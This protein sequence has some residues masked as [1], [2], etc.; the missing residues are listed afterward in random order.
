MAIVSDFKDMIE[1]FSNLSK[2]EITRVTDAPALITVLI[3]STDEKINSDELKRALD[4]IKWKKF[5]ARPDLT[6]Y[7]LQ[8][9]KN[10]SNRMDAILENLSSLSKEDRIRFLEEELR[11][12]NGIMPKFDREFAEQLYKSFQ[13]L[14]KGVAG[15][16]GGFL[17]YLTVN[18][19]E[20]KL[21]S[22]P[23][24]DDPRTYNV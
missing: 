23:M 7:Y 6:E 18:Y 17:G 22:L 8:V 10:F 15:A 14:A 2:E 9:R 11:K 13:E 1:Q 5:H 20:S 24:I 21:V 19:D 3:A 4:L 12:L 16:S